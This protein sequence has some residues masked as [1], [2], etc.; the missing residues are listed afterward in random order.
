[1]SLSYLGSPK[2]NPETRVG[3]GSLLGWDPRKH[4]EGVG[5]SE[6]REKHEERMC[7]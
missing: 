2:E 4:S 6:D 5:K 7:S 1:M 3:A